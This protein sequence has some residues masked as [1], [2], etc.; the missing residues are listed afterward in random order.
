VTDRELQAL[1]D[2]RDEGGMARRVGALPAPE[3]RRARAL[4]EL[5]RR[6]GDLPRATPGPD[7]ADRAMARIRTRPP[8]R[9]T[10]AG[11]LMAPRLSALGAVGAAAA[12]AFLAIAVARYPA[13][14]PGADARASLPAQAR[15]V[16]HLVLEAPSA[17]A[18]AVAGDFNGW[19]PEASP[20]HRGED[21]RWS[22]EIPVE[23][24]RRYEYMFVVD[25]A[26]VTDP[27]ARARAADG[28]GGENAVL[29]L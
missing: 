5:S 17:R 20:L 10:L 13:R 29:D 15:R 9:L 12:A 7:F 23:A 3:R 24:G 21:G 25:G 19:R 11:W 6:A 18:V 2:A 4:A 22:V 28:F 1:L 8:P 26:W 16:A 27:A 14:A